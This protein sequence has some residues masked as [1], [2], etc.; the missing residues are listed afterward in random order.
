MKVL[1]DTIGFNFGPSESKLE[2]TLEYTERETVFRLVFDGVEEQQTFTNIYGDP[3]VLNLISNRDL[4]TLDEAYPDEVERTRFVKG[5]LYV[6]AGVKLGHMGRLGMFSKLI[7]K[8]KI[9]EDFVHREMLEIVVIPVLKSIRDGRRHLPDLPEAI[10]SFADTSSR[11]LSDYLINEVDTVNMFDEEEFRGEFKEKLNHVNATLAIRA[12]QALTASDIDKIS[13]I[14]DTIYDMNRK[15][16]DVPEF[17]QLKDDFKNFCD[18]IKSM[19]EGNIQIQMIQ[20][21]TPNELSTT[22][23]KLQSELETFRQTMKTIEDSMAQTRPCKHDQNPNLGNEN[24]TRIMRNLSR[25]QMKIIEK[26]FSED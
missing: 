14:G 26:M 18:Q 22:V 11:E 7:D 2:V 3:T 5:V 24:Q 10:L 8:K 12:V 6:W 25:K 1:P 4:S 19:G 23:E 17:Q 16:V 21:E 15:K 13:S 9:F 20:N